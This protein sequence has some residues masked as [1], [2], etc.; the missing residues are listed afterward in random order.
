MRR[1][2]VAMWLLCL[3]FPA[4]GED[5]GVRYSRIL[6]ACIAENGQAGSYN[7]FDG[8][9]SVIH[10]LSVTC[11]EPFQHWYNECLTIEAPKACL[12]HSV[13]LAQFGLMILGK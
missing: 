10:L 7:S 1:Y 12:V 11:Q 2:L 6:A 9:R 4:I 13:S 8:G 5:A 3:T